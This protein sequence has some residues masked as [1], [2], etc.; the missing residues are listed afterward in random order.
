MGPVSHRRAEGLGA[1]GLAQGPPTAAATPLTVPATVPTAVTPAPGSVGNAPVTPATVVVT[2]PTGDATAGG[3][4]V[5][6]APV[7]GAFP[8]G[9]TPVGSTPAG[10]VGV[11]VGPRP[12]AASVGSITP[13]EPAG[14]GLTGRPVSEPVGADAPAVPEGPAPDE[15]GAAVVGAAP[16]GATDWEAPRPLPRAPIRA[17]APRPKLALWVTLARAAVA[18]VV[19]APPDRLEPADGRGAA[20][21]PSA[22][23]GALWA[24]AWT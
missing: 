11:P 3:V 20:L 9:S 22:R 10:G 2:V 1:V 13:S 24:A 6:G 5:V 12:A 18:D 17:A 19:P 23:T 4:P 8:V 14:V 16:A 21:C 7:L 15:A